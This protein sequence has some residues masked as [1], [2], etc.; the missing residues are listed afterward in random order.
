MLGA[1]GDDFIVTP[2]AKN[3]GDQRG[4]H[5]WLL[6]PKFAQKCLV[7]GIICAISPLMNVRKIF[8]F[9][10]FGFVSCASAGLAADIYVAQT[11]QGANN[12]TNAANAHSVAWLNTA[13][14]I[15]GDIVHLCGTIANNVTIQPSGSA[16]NPITLYFEPNAKFSAPTWS[17]S[18]ITISGKNITVDGGSN[19]LIEAT[20]N[21]TGLAYSND[22]S[23]ITIGSSM[24]VTVKNLLVRNLYVNIAGAD[25]NGGG[26]GIGASGTVVG[27]V[28]TNCVVHDMLHGIF[29]VIYAGCSNLV[30]SHCTAYN[31]NWGI[32]CGDANGSATLDGLTVEHCHVYNWQNWTDNADNDHNN[33]I[34]LFQNYGTMNNLKV[35]ANYVGPGYSTHNT[36]GVYI[37]ANSG[38]TGVIVCNNIFDASDG[39]SPA[40]G[41]INIT[42]P[43]NGTN[44]VVNN[45]FV[46]ANGLTCALGNGKSSTYYA[47]FNNEFVNNTYAIEDIYNSQHTLISDY[48]H[49]SAS[50]LYWISSGGSLSELSFL[51]LQ[52]AG[53]DPHSSV[54]SLDN[55]NGSYV[56]QVSS[57]LIGAGIN[58]TSLG[59]TTDYAGN[60]RPATGA[61]TIGAYVA[62]NTNLVPAISVTPASQNFGT[63]AV[64][65]TTNQSFTV[66]N[67]GT[68]TLTGSAGVSA[69]FSIVSGGSYSLGA[70]QSQ[71]VTIGYSPVA[72]G[73][74]SQTVTF[75][76]ASGGSGAVTGTAVAIPVVSAI[77]QSGADVDMN[78]AGLQI[79]AGSVVQ[80]SGS[81]SDPNGLPLTWQWSYSLNGGP[82]TV[83]QSG[84]GS[85]PSVS[86]NYTASTAGNTYVWMLVASNGI[87]T[88]V[89]TLTIGVEAPPPATASLT[90][91]A[92]NAVI[93][94]PFALTSGY[95]SQSVQTTDPT[96][97][98]QAVFT[99]TIT[100]ASTYVIQA[101]VNAP[102]DANNSLFVNMDAQPSDPTNIWDI[103]ITSGFEQ[104]IVSWR[105]NGTDVNNQYVPAVF[106]L[107]AGVHQLIIRGREMNVQLQSVAIL[108]YVTPP[109]NLHTVG[110]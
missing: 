80:Y 18:I 24:N 12:G 14:L 16:G 51:L 56:P 33:G 100:N 42:T 65:A 59:I 55:L 39:T 77:T 105:G 10:L 30:A 36:A 22:F 103:P 88:A 68:G 92:T 60:P 109:T 23:G 5:R 69:P 35:N 19:G 83:V 94:A 64:G 106:T 74:N 43:I 29:F 85:V 47:S 41:Q 90:F 67:S 104:R 2:S 96:T 50:S 62:A 91:Q 98:G 17:G 20:A 7:G 70:G 38:L 82:K 53:Y 45:T 99:F 87:S 86:F 89:S 49:Y 63:I 4:S 81:A 79:Y 78:A 13:S 26:S 108:D 93:T 46:G 9:A 32:A 15:A 73:T 84:A 102:N 44:Y 1:H 66:K 76:G 11:A 110:P 21:G 61:W 101:L 28:I 95:I 31:C 8:A 107:S 71:T 34:F 52:A 37:S 27:I 57:S 97:G 25:E 58:L 48:N 54:N 40:Y 6:T 75:T 3:P 72:A